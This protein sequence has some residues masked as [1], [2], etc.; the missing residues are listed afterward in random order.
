MN[1]HFSDTTLPV[2]TRAQ[3]RTVMCLPLDKL[4]SR[5]GRDEKFPEINGYRVKNIWGSVTVEGQLWWRHQMILNLLFNCYEQVIGEKGSV[6]VKVG[7]YSLLKKLGYD[8]PSVKDARWLVKRIQE[9]WEATVTFEFEG[10]QPV[11]TRIIYEIEGLNGT[12]WDSSIV[13]HFTSRYCNFMRSKQAMFLSEE[14]LLRLHKLPALVQA[15]VWHMMSHKVGGQASLGNLVG[16]LISLNNSQ[17]TTQ[18][19]IK[20]L[21]QHA[22]EMAEF[23]VVVDGDIVRHAGMAI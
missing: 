9:L 19:R 23:G 21:R 12:G 8:H 4:P 13:F 7:L 17:R 22:D 5:K 10:E 15:A 6:S 3:A 16:A 1:Q 2:N 18:R 11:R 14:R 20:Q